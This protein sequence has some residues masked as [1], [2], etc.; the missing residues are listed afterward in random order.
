MVRNTSGSIPPTTPK[1][2]YVP[3][4]PRYT[5]EIQTVPESQLDIEKTA[6]L[7]L[8]CI[9]VNRATSAS[10]K[11]RVFSAHVFRFTS[12]SVYIIYGTTKPS[13]S[14]PAGVLML[15]RNRQRFD[16]VGVVCENGSLHAS[17]KHSSFCL[18][19]QLQLPTP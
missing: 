17:H 9:A 18:Q 14:I 13:G 15:D 19:M 5:T 6:L 3:R 2:N 16:C 1:D 12:M 7:R 8:Q 11:L 10:T 4:S